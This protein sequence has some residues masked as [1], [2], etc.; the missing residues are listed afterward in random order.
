MRAVFSSYSIAVQSIGEDDY[1]RL[2][3]RYTL[4][5]PIFEHTD[6]FNAAMLLFQ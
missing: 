4:L 1:V 2:K 5:V 3:V 6:S